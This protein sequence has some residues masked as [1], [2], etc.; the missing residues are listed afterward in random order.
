M[1]TLFQQ[2]HKINSRRSYE[3]VARKVRAWRA[4][5]FEQNK[6]SCKKKFRVGYLDIEASDLSADW[7]FM[8]TWYIKP[9]GS[10]NYD[11]GIITQKEILDG[12]YDYRITKEL[13]LALDNYDVIYTHWGADRRFDLP[14]IRTRAMVHN[15][16]K[17]L[18]NYLEKFLFDTWPIARNK[19]RLRRNSLDNIARTLGITGIGKTYLD[20]LIWKRAHIGDKKSLEYIAK[21]N[22]H[23]VILLERVHKKLECVERKI[24]RSM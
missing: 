16:E 5:G 17:M 22:K 14:F 6:D 4:K 2:I 10:R 1:M 20:P 19:L 15:L 23:D 8:L 21:H 18:P 24:Y 9:R 13:L 12:S 3:G 11:F 7:G